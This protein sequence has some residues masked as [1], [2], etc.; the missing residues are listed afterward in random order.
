MKHYWKKLKYMKKSLYSLVLGLLF[1]A[2][3]HAVETEYSKI[4]KLITIAIKYPQRFYKIWIN[5]LDPIQRQ[6]AQQKMLWHKKNI[7]EK[8]NNPATKRIFNPALKKSFWYLAPTSIATLI[9]T[10]SFCYL[11]YSLYY[12]T[13]TFRN[14]VASGGLAFASYYSAEKTFHRFKKGVSFLFKGLNYKSWLNNKSVDYDLLKRAIDES[15][16]KV[17]SLQHPDETKN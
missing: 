8:R 5:K 16:S 9:G 14:L 1:C 13:C 12:D 10:S 2:H 11:L 6:H 3:T 7:E 17:N 15:E 4:P